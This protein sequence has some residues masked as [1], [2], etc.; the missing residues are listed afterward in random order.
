M[1]SL[2]HMQIIID[3]V[4][5]VTI[6]LLLH[7]LSKRMVKQPPPIDAKAV[8][9]LEKIMA[10]SQEQVTHF[11]EAVAENE[12]KMGK[13]IRQLDSKEKRLLILLEQAEALTEQI[14]SRKGES[15]PNS[16]GEKYEDIL[17]MVKQGLSREEVARRSGLTEGEIN[18]VIELAHARSRGE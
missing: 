9:E 1:I 11:L 15:E 8:R 17:K 2:L 14:D 10:N 4:F 16:S 7:Q 18:L 5:F 6:L 3:V 12:T 13:L